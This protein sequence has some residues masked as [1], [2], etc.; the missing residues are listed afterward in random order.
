MQLQVILISSSNMQ[1][2]EK[3]LPFASQKGNRVVLHQSRVRCKLEVL[4]ETW[5]AYIYIYSYT[6][7]M[8]YYALTNSYIAQICTF[9]EEL[10]HCT[11]N[12][13]DDKLL[14]CKPPCPQFLLRLH[15]K[16]PQ[17]KSLHNGG[18]W[19]SGL[20][21]CGAIKSKQAANHSLSKVHREFLHANCVLNV[22]VGKGKL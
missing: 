1:K 9:C 15:S 14:D 22:C 5:T 6:F 16:A 2:Y 7:Y 8:H 21:P 17:N 3:K 4:G 12:S 13:G 11:V 20:R 10:R 19:V 18:L